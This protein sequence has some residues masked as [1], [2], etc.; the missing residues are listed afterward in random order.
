MREFLAECK[1]AVLDGDRE[2]AVGLAV[3]A[4]DDGIEVLDVIEQGFA[5]GI[6][7]AGDRWEKG[8]YFLPELAFS[9][10]SM[11]AAMETLRPALIESGGKGRS[12]GTVVIGTVQGD[13]HD[14]GKMLVATMLAANGYEI[15]DL[16]ADVAHD[17]FV[18][19]VKNQQPDLLCMSAL[20]TT[21]MMGQKTIIDMLS[22]AGIRNSV[23]VL[24]GGAPATETWASDIGAD[25][26]ADNAV[27]AV[28]KADEILS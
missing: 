6:R 10:E 18:S 21:T 5:V 11:K 7:E 13:I 12:K 25:G 27:A 26:Y 14:I 15:V 2:R 28:H 9:A 17:R 22:E 20:L 24:I 19:E 8:E 16:G 1:N 4:I 3:R 23:K